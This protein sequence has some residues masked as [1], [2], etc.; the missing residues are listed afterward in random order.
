MELL[1]ENFY[2]FLPPDS[3]GDGANRLDP[4]FMKIKYEHSGLDEEV[5]SMYNMIIWMNEEYINNGQVGIGLSFE[6]FIQ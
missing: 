5:P 4:G 3:P 1:R 2:K 6:D